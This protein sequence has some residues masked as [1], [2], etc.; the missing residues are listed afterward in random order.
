VISPVS[1]AAAGT[2]SLT[3][4]FVRIAAI[5]AWLKPATQNP[6]KSA[7]TLSRGSAFLLAITYPQVSL[8]ERKAEAIKILRRSS[9]TA[10]RG[11]PARESQK[12][13]K[14]NQFQHTDLKCLLIE[15]VILGTK[16]N[17]CAIL[18]KWPK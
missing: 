4:A 9:E 7:R 12:S 17:H 5:D 13:V 16:N 8:A 14:P 6:S 1:L 15:D 10:P 18:Q 11:Q 3:T 2:I